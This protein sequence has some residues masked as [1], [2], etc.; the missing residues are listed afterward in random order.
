M[1]EVVG[2]VWDSVLLFTGIYFAAILFF[3]LVRLVVAGFKWL[4]RTTTE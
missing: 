1:S 4:Y 3:G 2:F